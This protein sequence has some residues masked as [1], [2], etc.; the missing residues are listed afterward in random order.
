MKLLL[1]TQKIDSNDTVLGFMIDWVKEFSKHCDAVLVI[2]LE[3]GHGD[4]PQNVQVLSLGKEEGRSRIKYISRFLKYIVK[5]RR[6]YD[7]VFVHMNPEYSIVGGLFWKLWGKK[8]ILWYNHS[9][10]NL[11]LKLGMFFA[12]K[13]CHTSPLAATA[14]TKKS[15]IMPV[16]ID[17]KTFNSSNRIPGATEKRILYLGRIAPIKNVSLIV[18]AVIKLLKNG[19]RLKLTIVGDALPKDV[20]YLNKLREVAKNSGFDEKIIF[21]TGVADRSKVAE[22]YRQNDFFINAS[23]GGLYDK[24]VFEAIACGCLPLVSSQAF[25]SL[26]PKECFY[27][28]GDYESLSL[29]IENFLKQPVSYLDNVSNE[30]KLKVIERH[31]LT[32]LVKNIK[33]LFV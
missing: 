5:G 32:V 12:D 20:A 11:K 1:V 10:S 4:L 15:Q 27:I 13:V 26:L 16:G 17:V 31:S 22:I 18:D 19:E 3:K 28:Q 7:G 24:T 25:K 29:V 23:P 14:G 33:Q 30:L 6:E 8:H 21:Q 9:S 2:C